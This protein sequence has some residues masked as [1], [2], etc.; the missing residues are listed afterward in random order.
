MVYISVARITPWN[1]ACRVGVGMRRNILWTAQCSFILNK[2]IMI[3][4]I[5]VFIS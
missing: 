1:I 5:L 3:S 2:I 4:N